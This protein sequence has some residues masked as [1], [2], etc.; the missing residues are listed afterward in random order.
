MHWIRFIRIHWIERTRALV[1][2][3]LALCALALSSVASAQVA[4]T[5]RVSGAGDGTSYPYAPG[6][7]SCSFTDDTHP[8]VAAI[9]SA[10]YAGAKMCGQ[11]VRVTGPRGSVDVRIVDQCPGCAPGDIDLNAAA[12]ASIADPAA[13]RVRVTWQTVACPVSGATGIVAQSGSNPFFANLQVRNHRYG[14]AKLEVQTAS[15]YVVAPRQTFNYF[16]LTA[17]TVPVPLSLPLTLRLTDVHGQSVSQSVST[18]APD[19]LNVGTEQF[20]TCSGDG[21]GGGPSAAVPTLGPIAALA[22]ALALAALGLRTRR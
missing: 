21:A 18:L 2:L 19:V 1:L 16:T 5:G 7:G 9:N 6:S 8:M 14:I 15:G 22:L 4:C 11:C 10:D 3:S 12:F 17:P 13:G 20:A